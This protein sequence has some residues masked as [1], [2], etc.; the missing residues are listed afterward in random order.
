MNNLKEGLGAARRAGL[1]SIGTRALL[2]ECGSLPVCQNVRVNR[3]ESRM[4]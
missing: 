2:H 4:F 3:H 1:T